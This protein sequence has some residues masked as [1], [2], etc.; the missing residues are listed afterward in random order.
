LAALETPR[1][2]AHDKSGI[3]NIEV[4]S[5]TAEELIAEALRRDE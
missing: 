3:W 4:P 5:K 1:I 2:V